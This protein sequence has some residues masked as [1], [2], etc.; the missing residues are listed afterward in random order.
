MKTIFIFSLAIAIALLTGIVGYN[1]LAEPTIAPPEDVFEQEA[2]RVSDKVIRDPTPYDPD[3]DKAEPLPEP[4]DRIVNAAY[5]GN[6]SRVATYAHGALVGKTFSILSFVYDGTYSS[7]T[8]FCSTFGTHEAIAPGTIK[9][10]MTHSNCPGGVKAPLTITSTYT[11]VEDKDG[12]ETM[13]IVTG[14]VKEIYT[15]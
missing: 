12:I 10:V 1:V 15:R 11:I 8:D 7:Q 4:P 13:T 6:W 2:D 9:M 14:P 3:K 5:V